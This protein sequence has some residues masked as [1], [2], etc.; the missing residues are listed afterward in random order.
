MCL[1]AACS[2]RGVRRTFLR[3]WGQERIKVMMLMI[4]EENILDWE[5]ILIILYILHIV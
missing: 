2:V 1:F 5:V 3:Y 4:S